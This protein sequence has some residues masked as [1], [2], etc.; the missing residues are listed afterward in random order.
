MGSVKVTLS[1]TKPFITKVKRLKT[2]SGVPMS[3]QLENAWNQKHTRKK[4]F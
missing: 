1:F 4:V 2:L 3:R